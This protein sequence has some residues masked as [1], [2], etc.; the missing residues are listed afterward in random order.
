MQSQMTPSLR[1]AKGTSPMERKVGVDVT[2]NYASGRPT[3]VLFCMED[4]FPPEYEPKSRPIWSDNVFD[5]ISPAKLRHRKPQQSPVPQNR[6]E[7][8]PLVT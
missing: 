4:N 6:L 7:P 1:H 5:R 2:S 3:K 8:L